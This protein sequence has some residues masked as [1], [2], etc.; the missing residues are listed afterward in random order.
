MTD[1]SK[2]SDDLKKA[3]NFFEK[4]LKK[5]NFDNESLNK[6]SFRGLDDEATNISKLAARIDYL[7]KTLV[8]KKKVVST[9]KKVKKVKIEKKTFQKK[10][11]Q[12]KKNTDINGQPIRNYY[13]KKLELASDK[14]I[15]L[16]NFE[17]NGKL[18]IA[19][20]LNKIPSEI[21]EQLLVDKIIKNR[22]D[23]LNNHLQNKKSF[24]VKKTFGL[25]EIKRSKLRN[26]KNLD[27][28]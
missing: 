1:N 14:Y 5:N 2:F 28:I 22:V 4:K 12:S 3:K 6:E 21:V 8:K 7:K 20:N 23:L 15:M 9:K 18:F 13:T 16:C 10:Y 19:G 17:I 25:S 11:E 26:K 27:N 24:F